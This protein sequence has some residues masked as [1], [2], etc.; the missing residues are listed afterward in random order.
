MNEHVL[1][2][3]TEPFDAISS[4]KKTIESRLFDD[5][6]KSINLGDTIIFINREN[7]S[8]NIRVK[9]IGLLRYETFWSL[10]THNRLAKFGNEKL[11]QLLIQINKFYS[12]EEQQ[13]YGVVGIEFELV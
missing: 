10:F 4:G 9:V 13:Q 11:D 3:A 2:L 6:R 12:D 7:S 5:K 1:Q 8:L